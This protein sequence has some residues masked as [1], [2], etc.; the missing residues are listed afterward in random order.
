MKKKENR[1]SRTK[2]P[3]LQPSLNL[4]TRYEE[5][6]DFD[7]FHKLNDSEKEWM[8]NFLEEY[9]NAR[10]KHPG[11]TLHRTKALKKSCYDRNN[12]RNRD[13]YSRGKARGMAVSLGD[14]KETKMVDNS[15]DKMINDFDVKF[16]KKKKTT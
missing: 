6:T 10:M 9:V 15:E 7:Y 2:F 1:R 4:K 16:Y 12:S 8:N 14:V 5:L 11:K 13:V 3:A